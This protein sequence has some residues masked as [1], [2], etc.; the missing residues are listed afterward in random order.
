MHF[1][2]KSW[3]SSLA[4]LINE[5]N[6]YF[7]RGSKDWGWG[8]NATL[9]S[10]SP[11]QGHDTTTPI[12]SNTKAHKQFINFLMILFYDA[13]SSIV[14]QVEMDPTFTPT[15]QSF[16]V[17]IPQ[18]NQLTLLSALLHYNFCSACVILKLWIWL[19]SCTP[20]ATEVLQ[21]QQHHILVMTVDCIK[22]I[23]QISLSVTL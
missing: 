16:G 18:P 15:P 21:Q 14:T 22:E 8:G 19:T 2:G 12:P 11:S 4:T 6:E 10:A 5:N 20:P 13:L 17:L 3:P 9:V 1:S 23:V 7:S